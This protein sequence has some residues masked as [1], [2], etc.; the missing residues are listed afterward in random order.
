MRLACMV[1]WVTVWATCIAFR[2]QVALALWALPPM[3]PLDRLLANVQRY[4]QQS[5]KDAHGHYV[6]ARL[7]SLAFAKGEKA[8]V[9]ARPNKPL[10]FHDTEPF[11]AERPKGAGAPDR[12]A[13]DHL[14]KSIRHYRIAVQLKP[15]EALYWLGLG[16]VLEQGM[17]FAN[18]L[19]APFLEKP[20]IVSAE[21]WRKQALNAYRQAFR[22]S[23][24]KEISERKPRLYGEMGLPSGSI[25]QEAGEAILR[26][27]R[28]RKLSLLERWEVNRVEGAL[29]ELKKLPRAITPIIFP[30]GNTLSLSDLVSSRSV[31]FDLNGDG[32]KERWQWVTPKA[33]FLVWD[34]ERTGQVTSGLQ[35]FGS[36][37]WWMF[38]RN[39][40][41]ALAALDDDGNGWLE[42]KELDGIFVWH[43]RNSNGVSERG[44]VLPLSHFGIVRI[45]VK[46]TNRIGETLFNPKGI[47]LLDGTF[48][49]T[50]DWVSKPV[51]P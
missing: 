28:G 39:G 26:L 10:K 14:A 2:H 41:E 11:F 6:L 5:P 46:A 3:A 35:L 7:H 4:V 16:W 29:E 48:L 19:P 25:A 33:C 44:E 31:I 30:V 34:G 50:Y 42:G 8:Y 45:S 24:E 40:Y 1:A 13:L 37:T 36:V 38:W 12:T 9:A 18:K 21:E 20:E 49:P 43:D 23:F 32:I 15:K 17:K 22:L 27:Q 47:Q 51:N